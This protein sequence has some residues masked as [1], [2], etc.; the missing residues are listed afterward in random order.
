MN[1]S[2]Y[3]S[4][5]KQEDKDVKLNEK[6][7]NLISDIFCVYLFKYKL[8]NICYWFWINYVRIVM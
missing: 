1:K 3:K 2:N 7:Y 8:K 5:N 6:D 4:K